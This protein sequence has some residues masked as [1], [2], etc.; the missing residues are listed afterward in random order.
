METQLCTMS[1]PSSVL[2]AG[3]IPF[4]VV[5]VVRRKKK[6][7]KNRHART[8]NSYSK[9]DKCLLLFSTFVRTFIFRINILKKSGNAYSPGQ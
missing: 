8:K 3:W 6:K 9:V 5:I 4:V 2:A 7:K 1:I